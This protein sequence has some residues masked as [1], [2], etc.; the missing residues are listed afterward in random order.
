MRPTLT[1][2]GL[3]AATAVGVCLAAAAPAI[4]PHV[5]GSES[6]HRIKLERFVVPPNRSAGLLAKVRING[7]PQLRLLVDSGSQYLVLD[8]SAA[9][10]SHCV[11]GAAD[12][13]LVGA[14]AAAATRVKQQTADIVEVGDLTLRSVPVIV[15]DRALPDGIQGALPL[16]IFSAFLVRLDF[17]AKELDLL[18]YPTGAADGAA[19]VPVLASNQLLFVKG[20]VNEVHDGYFLLDTGAAFAAISLDL[21]ARLHISEILAAHVT[22]RGGVADIDAPLLSGSVRLRFASRQP[23]TGPVVAVDLSTASRYHGF[24]VSGIIGSSALCDSILT[25]NFRDSLIGIGPK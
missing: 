14:G 10:R 3:A 21:A 7:G 11:G 25:V 8:R 20:T 2:S 24:E 4:A 12:L 18:P 16:S 13:D 23:V 15:S 9:L 1:R 19:A 5:T 6:S 17:R 22:L